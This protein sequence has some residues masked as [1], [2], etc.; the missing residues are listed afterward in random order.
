MAEAKRKSRTKT[1]T[2]A[3]PKSQAKSK[4]QAKSKSQAKTKSSPAKAKKQAKS[5]AEKP[6]AKPKRKPKTKLVPPPT[7]EQALDWLGLKVDDVSGNGIGKVSGLLVDTDSE[8][9]K[10]LITKMGMFTGEAGIPFD[11]VAEA[12]GRI[13]AAYDRDMVRSSPKLSAGQTLNARQELQLCEH[14]G[15]RDTVGRAAELAE[16]DGDEISAEPAEPAEY[17]G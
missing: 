15:I 7:R 13:W 2:K 4:P 1:K 17:S 6:A 3:K 16:R 8:D 14:Y 12:G 9:P 11:H 5:A 10:W